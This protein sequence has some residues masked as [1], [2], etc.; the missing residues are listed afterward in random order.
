M[1]ADILV[2]D[3]EEDIRELVAGLLEDEGYDT[4]MAAN[5][6]EA[7]NEIAT[8]RPSLVF[9]DI[10]LQGSELDGLGILDKI[11]ARHPDLPVVMISGHGTIET[12]VAAI[13]R[14]AFDYIEKPFKSDR[15]LFITERALEVSKLR[16]EVAEL[17]QQAP[18]GDALTGES[19]A[20][21]QLQSVID[22]VAPTNSRIMIFGPTGAGKEMVARSIHNNS[23]RSNGNFVVLS[24]GGIASNA[25]EIELFGSEETADQPGYTGAFEKAHGGTLYLDEVSEMPLDVQSKILKV[26]IDQTFLRVGGTVRVPVDVRVISSTASDLQ[27]KIV[28]GLFR[29]DLLHRLAVVPVKVPG[30]AERREDIPLLIN[31]F[32]D[33]I[34]TKTGLP[35][36]EIAQDAMAILQGHDWPGNIRQLRNNI[37]RLLIL[38]QEDEDGEITADLLPKEVGDYLPQTPGAGGEHLM[39]LPLREAREVFEREYLL[40]QIKRFN[41]NVSKTAEFV[42]MERSALHRKLKSLGVGGKSASANAT[43]EVEAG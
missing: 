9:L 40:A 35:K 16:G 5:S 33:E 26:M 23:H 28:D 31:H 21:R 4:R 29:E 38:S 2:V 17:R 12:A 43:K 10:W 19:L 1:S 36:R 15:L 7:L 32:M 30:L 14:G 41:G 3:D 11:V 6:T 27:Q 34:C 25:V 13:K 18:K 8:R 20:L 39:S 42:G 37:E 24:A 22:R